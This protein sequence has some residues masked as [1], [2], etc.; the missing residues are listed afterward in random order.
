[1]QLKQ[2]EA[3]KINLECVPLLYEG[4]VKDFTELKAFLNRISI[5]G[6]TKIEGMVIKNYN[7][8]T[9]DKKYMKGKY[10]SEAFKE[11]HQKNWKVDGTKKEIV[12]E[13]I[14]GLRTEARWDKAIQHLKERDELTDSL[15]D[16]G[17]LLKEV[18][19]DIEK[20]EEEAIKD[21]LYK[22]FKKNILRGAIGGFPE[23]YKEKLAKQS[24]EEENV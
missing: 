3:Q 14:M 21:A 15:K 19:V 7:L 23:Y 24:F 1:P 20:E 16:I 11:T 2:E 8:Y 12:Q 9:A 18:Q 10:V 13:I 22:H 6:G 17:P 4:N 5:L